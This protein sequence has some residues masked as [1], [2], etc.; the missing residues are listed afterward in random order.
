MIQSDNLQN[1]EQKMSLF[2]DQLL[3]DEKVLIEKQPHGIFLFQ[4]IIFP[5]FIIFWLLF[6]LPVRLLKKK[7]T[8]VAITNKRVLATSGIFSPDTFEVRLSKVSNMKFDQTLL[9]RMFKYGKITITSEGADTYVYDGIA[10]AK[11]IRNV[12]SKVVDELENKEE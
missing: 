5:G 3:K 6:M 9:G 11:E 10:D 4:R 12:F 8:A 2:T 1:W 7:K